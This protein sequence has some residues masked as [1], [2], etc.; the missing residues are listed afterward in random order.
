MELQTVLLLAI[1]SHLTLAE[2]STLTKQTE[3]L[4][5]EAGVSSQLL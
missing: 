2:L 3:E 5:R 1:G 4:I